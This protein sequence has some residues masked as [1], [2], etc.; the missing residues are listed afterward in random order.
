[1]VVIVFIPFV[2]LLRVE[3]SVAALAVP[4]EITGIAAATAA[5]ALPTIMLRRDAGG[6]WLGSVVVMVTSLFL[7]RSAATSFGVYRPIV[8]TKS[9]SGPVMRCKAL[10]IVLQNPADWWLNSI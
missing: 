2:P 10:L 1:L 5:A 4:M 9:T 6:A 7:F 3:V 8:R